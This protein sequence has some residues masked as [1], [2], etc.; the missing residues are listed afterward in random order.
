[1][2]VQRAPLAAEQPQQPPAG[3]TLSP[4]AA[5]SVRSEAARAPF[6]AEVSLDL[7]GP[8]RQAED[9]VSVRALVIARLLAA[10]RSEGL[11]DDGSALCVLRPTADGVLG[12]LAGDAVHLSADR[13]ASLLSSLTPDLPLIT[14]S[15]MTVVDLSATRVR[16]TG[17]WGY[18]GRAIVTLGAIVPVVGSDQQDCEPGL[19]IVQ[20]SVARVSLTVQDSRAYAR[21]AVRALDALA[22]SM[23]ERNP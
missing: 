8:G 4:G 17:D 13:I 22:R 15:T 18:G 2:R 5:R 16:V 20:R 9:E 12:V 14:S 19:R 1:M 21:G 11:L 10:C 6:S 3:L 23:R 7:T